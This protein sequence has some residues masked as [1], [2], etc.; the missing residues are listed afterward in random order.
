MWASSLVGDKKKEV[1]GILEMK[2]T[3]KT[4]PPLLLERV[5]RWLVYKGWRRCECGNCKDRLVLVLNNPSDEKFHHRLS[6]PPSAL[7]L[8][9][10]EGLK[11]VAS[12][13]SRDADEL[14][15]EIERT[16]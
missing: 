6:I 13:Y 4:P 14:Y 10:W 11:E 2:I 15:A 9:P 8:F 1:V 7:A 3:V 12:F 5:V 16:L